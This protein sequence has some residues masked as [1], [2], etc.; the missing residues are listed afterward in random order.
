MSYREAPYHHNEDAQ[1]LYMEFHYSQQM[2]E[3][4]YLTLMTSFGRP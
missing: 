4:T 3:I 1:L 2:Q